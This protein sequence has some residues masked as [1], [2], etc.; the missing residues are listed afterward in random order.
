M[1]DLLVVTGPP[2]AGKSTVAAIVSAGFPRS[3]LVAGDDFFGF[4]DQ[5][6][7]APWLA[8][9]HQQNEVVT[10]AAAAA[11]GRLARGD[12]TVVYDGMIGP[13]LLA[14]FAAAAATPDVHYAILFPDEGTCV[15]RVRSRVGH[16]FTALG[17]T[18]HMYGEF[19]RASVDARHV[20]VD[21]PDDPERTAALIRDRFDEGTLRVDG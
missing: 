15:D 13:W 17:A 7:I 2:G 5:G 1:G 16:G 18:R 10:D 20:L 3:A 9:A 12:Y 21:P 4:L 14:R 11:A 19:A 6:A 8:E